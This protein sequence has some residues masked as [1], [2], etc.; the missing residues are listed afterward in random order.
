MTNH[1]PAQAISAREAIR[2]ALV[3]LANAYDQHDPN[4]VSC[5]EMARATGV[6]APTF[7]RY[8]S[9]ERPLNIDHL[10]LLPARA[11]RVV[12]AAV[13]GCRRVTVPTRRTPDSRLRR[14]ASLVGK[15]AEL[16]ERVL[17]DDR[18]DAREAAQLRASLYQIAAESLEGAADLTGGT[19]AV[20]A[21]GWIWRGIVPWNKGE[22]SRPIPGGF[23]GQCEYAAWATNGP[24][25]PPVKGVTSLPG[26]LQAA[27]TQDDKHHQTGKPVSIMRELVRVVRRDGVVLDPFAG[28]GSTGVAALLEGRRVILCERVPEY[29]A[30]ARE[31]LA[32]AAE[33]LPTP[34]GLQLT[35]GGAR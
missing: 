16:L 28:S 34:R 5:A 15:H 27:V 19:D 30:I 2:T 7:A 13:E 11:Y 3:G 1:E 31:R 24:L 10:P 26:F 33:V 12:L 32:D 17:S 29:A 21:G 14:L 9:G 23:R 20:Q 8:L 22:G 25:P 18:I 35:L 4:G 6:S